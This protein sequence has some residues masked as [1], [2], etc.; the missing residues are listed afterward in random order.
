M[1]YMR[2]A[3]VKEDGAVLNEQILTRRAA[4]HLRFA[5]KLSRMAADRSVSVAWPDVNHCR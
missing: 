5:S 3:E 2:R 4:F 1:I